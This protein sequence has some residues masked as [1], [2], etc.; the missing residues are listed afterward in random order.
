LNSEGLA[1]RR[2]GHLGPPGTYG[3]EALRAALGEGAGAVEL[4]A[5][6]TNRDVVLAVES[7]SVEAGFVPIENSVEGAVT[8]TL[9]A[10]VHDAPSVQIVGEVVWPVHHC[11]IASGNVPLEE[12]GVVASHPQALAQC[13]GF[14]ASKL[15]NA[16][17]LAQ[18]STAEAVRSAVERGGGS[19]AIGS[20]IAAEMYG[21]TVVESAVEDVTGNKTR[22]VWLAKTALDSPWAG[23]PMAAATRTSVVFSGFNDTSP[24]G[25]VRILSE[26]ADRD[27]NM[28][29]I[30]SRPERTALGHYL[31]FVD[32]DGSIE[33]PG[34][35]E[36]IEGV[37][38]K[39]RELRVLGS[40]NAFEA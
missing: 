20:A 30:E 24:G 6:D 7:G 25:L 28:S 29:K 38:T 39:V 2:I 8:E 37:R 22:F 15:P 5:L 36:S 40:F 13:A 12:I 27:V 35:A 32:L 33:D 17:K 10:L 11:L 18:V 9:D 31:F 14:I 26:F 1:P 21:G 16:S 23:N 3:E 4:V 19:A 34:V